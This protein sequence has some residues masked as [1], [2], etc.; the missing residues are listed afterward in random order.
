MNVRLPAFVKK[1][2]TTFEKEGHEIYIVG[3]AVRDLLLN[4]EIVDWD[5]TTSATP[6]VILSLFPDGFYDNQFGTVGV[7]DPKDKEKDYYG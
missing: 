5:F 4:R 3:G 1:I 7:V 2:L 6:K